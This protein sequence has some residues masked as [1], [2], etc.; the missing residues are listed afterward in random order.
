MKYDPGEFFSRRR[1]NPL[2]SGKWLPYTYI[3]SVSF[4]AATKTGLSVCTLYFVRIQKNINCGWGKK[5]TWFICRSAVPKERR[6]HRSKCVMRAQI[7]RN[8]WN[9]RQ[10]QMQQTIFGRCV[11]FRF[12]NTKL[13]EWEHDSGWHLVC[14]PISKENCKI[15]HFW[16]DV[17]LGEIYNHLT[18]HISSNA[19]I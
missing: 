18:T 13:V 5:A 6:F 11:R 14:K 16:R 7:A 10:P 17:F 9:P 3:S 4:G 2:V 12:W 1:S 8:D 19:R 15:C